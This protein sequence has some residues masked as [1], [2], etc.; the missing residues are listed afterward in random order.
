MHQVI[1]IKNTSVNGKIQDLLIKGNFIVKIAPK[2][3]GNAETVINGRGKAVVPALFN[4]HSHAAMTLF[5]GYADDLSLMEWLKEKIWPVEAKLT[6]E[7]CYWGA[8]LACLEMIKSGTVGFVDMYFHPLATAR[9]ASEMGMRLA[10]GDILLD[11]LIKDKSKNEMEKRIMQTMDKL[12]SFPLV[13]P[14]LNPH[15]LYTVSKEHLQWTAKIAKE[16]GWFVHMHISETEK[17][18]IDCVKQNGKRPIEFLEEIGFLHPKVILAHGVWLD[19]K[20]ARL[21][22]KYGVTVSHNPT[23]NMKLAVGRAMPYKLLKD[24]GVRI[25]LGT[26]GA[27][28]NNNLDL[29][30]AMKIAA[31]LQKFSTDTQTALPAAEAF[32]M[33]TKE[34]YQAFGLNGGVIREGALADLLLIDLKRSELT[35]GH[36]L[37]ADLVYSANGSCVDTVICDGKI[38]MQDRKVNGE[39]EILEK[40]KACAKRL[41]GCEK[42]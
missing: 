32:Q 38:L 10:T 17:E 1:L 20:E 12:A 36:D 33:A 4:T 35:P 7:D 13:L 11:V 25:A 14:T 30:E 42:T 40:A 41:L 3:T 34:A 16:K 19:S 39:K 37:T 2:I 26:D 31:L 21:L 6:E 28:S 18:V 23:S 24:A 5:R 9:A 8:K 22:G 15:A 27:G 29:F